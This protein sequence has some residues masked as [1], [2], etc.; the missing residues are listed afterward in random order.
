MSQTVALPGME[1]GVS[2]KDLKNV[3][4]RRVMLEYRLYITLNASAKS[5]F[6]SCT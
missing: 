5:H 1:A 6:L 4:R 2:K 3:I